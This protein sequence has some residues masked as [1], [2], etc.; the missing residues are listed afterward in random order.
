[1]KSRVSN[2]RK[3]S[4][5]RVDLVKVEVASTKQILAKEEVTSI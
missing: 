1:M 3:R 4:E 5:C 2:E